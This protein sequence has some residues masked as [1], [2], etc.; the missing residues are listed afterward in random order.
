[1]VETD[2][3]EGLRKELAFGPL[4]ALVEADATL[5]GEL[6]SLRCEFGSKFA[7]EVVDEVRRRKRRQHETPPVV[8]DRA[9]QHDLRGVPALLPLI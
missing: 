6:Q 4:D 9:V 8:I 3:L 5:R 1:M 7:G 2:T